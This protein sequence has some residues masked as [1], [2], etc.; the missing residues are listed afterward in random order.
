MTNAS[1]EI[2][3]LVSCVDSSAQS[4]QEH[5]SNESKSSLDENKYALEEQSS[6]PEST[7]AFINKNLK[8]K[9]DEDKKD[10]GEDDNEN[11]DE[12]E[13]EEEEDSTLT[14]SNPNKET[15]IIDL[16]LINSVHVCSAQVR[17][18]LHCSL[19]LSLSLSLN[20]IFIYFHLNKQLTFLF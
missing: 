13:E 16:S 7:L 19:F 4:T 2:E 15:N 6:P 14:I 5:N 20:R 18:S 10:Q 8:E 3:V 11:D 17:R 12:D 9:E 1:S